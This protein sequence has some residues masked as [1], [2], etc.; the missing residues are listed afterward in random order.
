MITR[1]LYWLVVLIILKPQVSFAATKL[2]LVEQRAL[3]IEAEAFTDK[4]N[5]KTYQS[6][7]QQLDGYPLKPYLEL[8]TLARFPIMANKAQIESFLIKYESSPL[9]RPL[10]KK[11]LNYLQQQNHDELFVASYRDVGDTKLTCRYAELLMKDEDTRAKALKLAETLWVVAKSQPKVCDSL[12][13]KWQGQGQRTSE[14]VWKRLVKVAKGGKQTLIP[15]LKTLLP[16]EQKYLADLWLKV[17]RHPS[18]VSRPSN[19]PNTISNLETE[20][21]TYGLKRLVWQDRD[22]ALRSWDELSKRLVFT[23]DQQKQIFHRFAIALALSNHEQADL[24]LEKAIEFG[25][26]SELSRWH[27]AHMIRKQDWQHA[28]DVADYAIGQGGIDNVFRYWQAIA[29]KELGA[30]ELAEQGFQYLA[31]QRHYYGFLASAQL[32]VNT[33]LNNNPV[34]IP[35]AKIN[36]LMSEPSAQRA[37]EF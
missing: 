27:L 6:Y 20:I 16:Q 12:F 21:A 9:D 1:Y 29:Y 15:Y 30:D 28:L 31:K 4:P 25:V 2:T 17:R 10:R 33:S 7:M 8:N 34:H 13:K 36:V 11:W 19:F 3:F 14:L 24:W 23:K 26:D 37:F 35:Q 32:S 18:Q 22:L 5:S